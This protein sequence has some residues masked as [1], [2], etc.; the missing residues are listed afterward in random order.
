MSVVVSVAGE[1]HTQGTQLTKQ[2]NSGLGIVTANVIT[3]KTKEYRENNAS[4]GNLHN[5]RAV[6]CVWCCLSCVLPAPPPFVFYSRL[7]PVPLGTSLR[8]TICVLLCLRVTNR[9]EIARVPQRPMGSQGLVASAQ[10]LG[11]MG[12]TGFYGSFDREAA[13]EESLR[14]IA[15]VRRCRFLTLTLVFRL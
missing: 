6:C 7:L 5:V 1:L 13:E 4:K 15:T 9:S 8:P 14:T 10:G 12:M 2:R 11:C 3:T